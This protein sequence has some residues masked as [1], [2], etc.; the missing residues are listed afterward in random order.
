VSI[1][2]KANTKYPRNYRGITV[3]SSTGRVYTKIL[4]AKLEKETYNI[5]SGFW[6]GRSC[7]ENLFILKQILAKRRGVN[8]ETR[9]ALVDLEKAYDSVPR[10]KL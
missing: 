6:A 1:F 2:K 10:C 3:G 4:K 8:E 9:L 5:F 7:T